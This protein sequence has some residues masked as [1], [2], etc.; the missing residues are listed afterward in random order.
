[1]L[2]LIRE[3][4][5]LKPSVAVRSCNTSSPV[6]TA[7]GL[8]PSDLASA[9]RG[10]LDCIVM[11]A[12]DKDRDRRY[13]SAGDLADDLRRYLRDE[14]VAA[15]PPSQS[16]VL[17]KFIRRHRGPVAATLLVA[18]ALIGGI[19]ASTWQALRA[20]RAESVALQSAA[21]AQRAA[22]SERNAKLEEAAQ[23]AL[24][25]ER[26]KFLLFSTGVAKF[27][28]DESEMVRIVDSL[29]SR[30]DESLGND[31][32][33]KAA[34][35]LHVAK[36]CSKERMHEEAVRQL[37]QVLALSH[38][39]TIVLDAKEVLGDALRRTGQTDEAADV[40]LNLFEDLLGRI[41]CPGAAE[42]QAAWPDWRSLAAAPTDRPEQDSLQL[43]GDADF[44]IIPRLQ[45]DGI[46]PWTLEAI[47]KPDDIDQSVVRGAGRWTSIIS[48]TDGGG[49]GLE[50]SGK[51][52][53]IGMFSVTDPVNDPL[54]NWAEAIETNEVALH[55][56]QHIAGVWDG[57]EMRLYVNGRLSGSCSNV[58]SCQHL[59]KWPFYIGA[60]PCDPW[61]GYMAEGLFKGC[62][63]AVRISRG[64]EY[65]ADF[66]MPERLEKT[67]TTVALYDFTIDTGRYAIDRSGRGHH[68]ILVGA[69]FVPAE[70][71]AGN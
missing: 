19:A 64:V 32:E 1:M 40:L 57:A 27:D 60:D 30:L 65:T 61:Y 14:P 17:R 28:I 70:P 58:I 9:L 7:T 13:Q 67:P 63:R 15:S 49:I 48:T 16:Y 26:F 5:A 22:N 47:V 2:R 50:T 52:W 8:A 20:T 59:T 69:T 21:A 4:E 41:A 33:L 51:K 38:E 11:K 36:V 6:T 44:I 54:D 23:R 56:W 34:F 37:R 18:A 55:Q 3:D 42:L 24:A 31:P 39:P 12:I 53:S 35:L 68:G 62:I 46:P 45:F 66:P 29:S 43:D 71:K 10:D 25:E